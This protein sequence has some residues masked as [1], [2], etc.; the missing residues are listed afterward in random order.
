MTLVEIDGSR[1]QL[2]KTGLKG[3]YDRVHSLGR[4]HPNKGMPPVINLGW[5]VYPGV[6]A[7]TKSSGMRRGQV[8]QM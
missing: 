2:V 8:G 5:Q 6:Q 7:T 4:Q 3:F 1:F